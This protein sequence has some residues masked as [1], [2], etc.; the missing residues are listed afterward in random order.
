MSLV[1]PLGDEDV[2]ALKAGDS[3]LISGVVYGARDAA[4][5]RLVDLIDAGDPLPFPV[6]GGIIYYVGPTPAPEGMAIG[7][8]GPTT[9][10][11]MDK[12]APGLY[13]LGLRGTI[14]KGERG[15]EVKRAIVEK[16]GVYFAATGGVG[17]L[18]SRHIQSAK[19]IAYGELGPEALFEFEFIDFPAVVAIDCH[20]GDIFTIGRER[21]AI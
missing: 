9:A 3:V 1:T 5:K 17:A 10:A 6:E 4:H 16:G 18:L 11:R 12:Y 2:R 19:V 15:D 21:Y 7:S 20:G 8:A 13:S 14:G